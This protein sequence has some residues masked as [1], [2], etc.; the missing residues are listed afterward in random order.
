MKSHFNLSF[1]SVTLEDL[2]DQVFILLKNKSSKAWSEIHKK[3]EYDFKIILS[4]CKGG[5]GVPQ[6]S[7]LSY[8]KFY[9]SM[10]QHLEEHV[11][12]YTYLLQMR[13]GN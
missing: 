7:K 10:L 6:G 4:N 5:N 12:F 8:H 1:G 13:F 3:L 11:Y 2:A 9:N